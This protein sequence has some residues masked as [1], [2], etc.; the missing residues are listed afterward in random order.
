ML[1]YGARLGPYQLQEIIGVGSFGTVYKGRDTRLDRT[2]AIKI[3]KPSIASVPGFPTRFEREARAVAQLDHPHICALH[4]VGSSEGLDYLVMQYLDGQTLA[5]RLKQGTIPLNDVLN[6]S[7]DVADALTA[8]HARGIVHRDLKAGNVMITSRGAVLFDFGLAKPEG[9][10]LTSDGVTTR[11]QLTTGGTVL[12]TVAYMAPEQL[13]G[14]AVDARTDVWA[15]GALLFEGVTGRRAFD[16]AGPAVVAQILRDEPPPIETLRPGVPAQ[17]QRLVEG[18]LQKSPPARWQSITIV[19]EQLAAIRAQRRSP[20]AA[21]PSPLATPN[22]ES[23]AA[24]GIPWWRRPLKLTISISVSVAGLFLILV[25]AGPPIKGLFDSVTSKLEQAAAPGPDQPIKRELP[26]SPR[27]S[28]S[29]PE[30]PSASLPST[31]TSRTSSPRAA[32]ASAPPAVLAVPF[33]ANVSGTYEFE[34][35]YPGGS[36]RAAFSHALALPPGTTQLRIRNTLYFLDQTITVRGEA[37][38]SR[39]FTA[40]PLASVAVRAWAGAPLDCE[41][42]IDGRAAGR[43]DDL[44]SVVTGQHEFSVQCQG[45][46]RHTTRQ[47]VTI[48]ETNIVRIANQD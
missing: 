23:A 30:T 35:A 42:A 4:D 44:H 24:R 37:G 10:G 9:G 33:T 6:W 43:P 29:I 15:F 26:A 48:G 25:L 13:Q 46:G 18:C 20:V 38:E 12:G 40:P 1:E 41:V 32:P 16:A 7:L 5:A 3:L 34:V 14:H 45:G 11:E 19:H 22:S 36:R 17:L 21:I 47:T 27:P 8:A 28:P 31:S 39:T 2:V